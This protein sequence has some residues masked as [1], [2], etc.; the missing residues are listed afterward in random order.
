[1]SEN[2]FC[3][4]GTINR[5]EGAIMDFFKGDIIAKVGAE[6]IFGIGIK[7]NVISKKGSLF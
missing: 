2:P 5:L 6:A 1:M 7:P 3:G 4:S